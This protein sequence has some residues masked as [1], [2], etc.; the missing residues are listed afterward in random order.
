MK[1]IIFI[2]TLHGESTPNQELKDIITSYSPDNIFVEIMQS[3]IDSNN[4]DDYPSEMVFSLEFAKN[5]SIPFF[6][7]DANINILKKGKDQVSHKEVIDKQ[8]EI[9]KLYD[10]KDFNKK[11]YGLK[12][13]EVVEDW[14]DKEKWL[15]REEEMKNN[16]NKLLPE[17][18]CSVVITGSGHIEFFQQHFLEADF[19]FS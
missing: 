3:D 13:D 9:I 6:G 12:L 1:K 16:I 14:I 18:G 15:K 11:E 10:W 19:P 4:I 8:D 2:G 17:E 5:N 7:F